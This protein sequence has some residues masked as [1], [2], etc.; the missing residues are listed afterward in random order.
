MLMVPKSILKKRGS[1]DDNEDTNTSTGKQVR[2]E[3]WCDGEPKPK[4]KPVKK[5]AIILGYPGFGGFDE[6]PKEEKSQHLEEQAA[7][8]A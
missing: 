4:L 6:E 1:N 5:P 3:P 2:F 8:P 7:Q